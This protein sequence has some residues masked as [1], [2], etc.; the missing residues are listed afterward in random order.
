M[1]VVGQTGVAGGRAATSYAYHKPVVKAADPTKVSVGAY[2]GNMITLRGLALGETEL[3]LT[4]NGKEKR[5]PVTV[6]EGIHSVLWVSGNARTIFAG[7]S[8]QWAID[9]KTLSGGDNPYDVTWK[10]TNPEVVKAEQTGS[11]NKHG[12]IT[13]LAVGSSDVTAEVA[14]VTSDVATVQVIALPVDLNLTAA[15]IDQQNSA[16]YDESGNLVV[17]VAPTSGYSLI[18]LTLPY[19]GGS[20]DGQ[21]SLAGATLNIDGAEVEVTSG[22]LTVATSAGQTTVSYNLSGNVGG[23]VFSI[24]V[25]DIPVLL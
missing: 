6:T 11:D 24:E 23:K 12:T 9:A 13:G 5:V 7:Q 17:L 18:T 21:Y 14:G 10:S 1:P 20:Y 4:S 25:V 19:N 22:S 16:I 8:V 2:D 15:D 3:I